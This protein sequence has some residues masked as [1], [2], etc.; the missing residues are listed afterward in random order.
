MI[1]LVDLILRCVAPH[2][3]GVVPAGNFASICGTIVGCVHPDTGNHYTIVEPQLGGWGG[4]KGRDGNSAIFSGLHGDTFNCPAEVAEARYGLAVEQLA[5]NPAPG[6]EGQW[7]GGKGVEV[8][9]RVRADNNLLSVGY[10]RSRIP[11]WGVEGGNDGSTN[12]VEVLRPDQPTEHYAYGAKIP[13]NKGDLIRVVTG[14]G[15]GYGEPA[16]RPVSAVQS[17]VRNGYIS[18]ARARDVYGYQP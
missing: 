13:L 1:R 10:T 11:P 9:Y 2:L 3:E 6:G 15:G 12:F 16:R 14:S 5:L 18:A 8:H 7:T 4:R 17:D